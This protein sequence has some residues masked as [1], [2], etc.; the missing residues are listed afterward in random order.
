MTFKDKHAL[1]TLPKTIA[2]LQEGMR[3]LQAKLDDPKFYARDPLRLRE[4][5]RCDGGFAAAHRRGRRA[6]AGAGDLARGTGRL[7]AM[8]SFEIASSLREA[9]A[10][11]NQVFSA[12]VDCFA[13]L[14]MTMSG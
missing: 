12:A 13:S 10:T 2:S 5:L 7:N 9:M 3:K 14:A 11:N 8:I 4:G 1:E 6:M